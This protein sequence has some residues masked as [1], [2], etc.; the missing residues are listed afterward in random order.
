MFTIED[1]CL[2]I[3]G[4]SNYWISNFPFNEVML[5]LKALLF[6]SCRFSYTCIK[7]SY[8]IYVE[9]VVLL[10]LLPLTPYMYFNCVY[11]FEWV[12]RLR[13][14]FIQ[15]SLIIEMILCV[16]KYTF[17]LVLLFWLLSAAVLT[18]LYFYSFSII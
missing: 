1:I 14:L 13:Q 2:A 11:C 18:A 7:W 16:S 17:L 15:N 3:V 6:L 8:K 9:W 12:Y 10:N 5:I 4:C